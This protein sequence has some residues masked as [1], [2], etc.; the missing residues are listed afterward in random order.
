M[1]SGA[2]KNGPA[3]I[4]FTQDISCARRWNMQ[5]TGQ[6]GVAMDRRTILTSAAASATALALSWGFLTPSKPARLTGSAYSQTV[7]ALVPKPKLFAAA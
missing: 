1:A 3:H 2:L 4:L 5:D 7:K 6:E